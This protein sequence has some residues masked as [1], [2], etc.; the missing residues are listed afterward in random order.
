MTTKIKSTSINEKH[1]NND[2]EREEAQNEAIIP[3]IPNEETVKSMDE[4]EKEVECNM[5][6]IEVNMDLI[7]K[8]K[9]RERGEPNREQESY[10]SF[11]IEAAE[12]KKELRDMYSQLISLSTSLSITRCSFLMLWNPSL[13]RRLDSLNKKLDLMKE[14][15]LSNPSLPLSTNLNQNINNI[16][17]DGQAETGGENVK[18]E[19]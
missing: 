4:M 7:D 10:T 18:A 19:Q 16:S 14:I 2:D 6:K 17:R 8:E 9:E 12:L 11:I 5:K 13:D 3:T 1:D 15:N